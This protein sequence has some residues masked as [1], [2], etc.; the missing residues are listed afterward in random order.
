MLFLSCVRTLWS[1]S[2][3]TCPTPSL[4][5]V[6]SCKNTGLSHLRGTKTSPQRYGTCTGKGRVKSYLSLLGEG[7]CPCFGM[8]LAY[9]Y[10]SRHLNDKSVL[11][12]PCAMLVLV[13]SSIVKGQV[14]GCAFDLI[15]PNVFT[16]FFDS[17]LKTFSP[18]VPNLFEYLRSYL[19]QYQY[20]EKTVY[21]QCLNSL[22][23]QFNHSVVDARQ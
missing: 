8:R 1:K 11:K 18:H 10:F 4:A 15:K 22:F 17:W 20:I 9:V 7:Q 23:S 13:C 3:P 2:I 19:Q 12:I 6:P 14:K 5:G 21:G 16:S